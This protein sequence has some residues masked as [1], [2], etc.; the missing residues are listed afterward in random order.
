MLVVPGLKDKYLPFS[1]PG[2]YGRNL[3][4]SERSSLKMALGAKAA[5]FP[6]E[7]EASILN[8]E[9]SDVTGEELLFFFN[10]CKRVNIE[11]ETIGRVRI[12]YDHLI[13]DAEKGIRK[14]WGLGDDYSLIVT[15]AQTKT[16]SSGKHYDCLVDGVPLTT[17][18]L[19]HAPEKVVPSKRTVNLSIKWYEDRRRFEEASWIKEWYQDVLHPTPSQR[20]LS[21]FEK[22]LLEDDNFIPQGSHAVY[23]VRRTVVRLTRDG[24]EAEAAFIAEKY[25]WFTGVEPPPKYTEKE[26][27]EMYAKLMQKFRK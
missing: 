12:H 26:A 3:T 2:K 22:R 16:T 15:Y 23:N 19:I 8:C 17:W 27:D 7:R 10:R 4:Q 9:A 21:A 1:P 14:H 18:A 5:A 24:F 13:D 25:G 20:Q 6:T 11:N